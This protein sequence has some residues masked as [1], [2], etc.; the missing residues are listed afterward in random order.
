MPS[1][2]YAAGAE[3]QTART[4]A[5]IIY[6]S[7]NGNDKSGDGTQAKP[8]ATLQRAQQEIRK[9]PTAL[10]GAIT[11]LVSSG[12]YYFNSTLAFTPLDSGSSAANPI[13]WKAADGADAFDDAFQ[14][15]VR[16]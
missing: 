6:V 16:E 14:F 7:I 5:S 12:T 3:R 9:T 2:Y 15:E 13:V 10:R 11:V 8:F 1:S 4:S